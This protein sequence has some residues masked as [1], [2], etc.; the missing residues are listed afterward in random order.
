[1][2]DS[3]RMILE[4]GQAMLDDSLRL[5]DEQMARVLRLSGPDQ[6][7]AA[8]HWFRGEIRKAVAPLAERIEQLENKPTP[9]P[10]LQPTQQWEKGLLQTLGKFIA[11]EIDKRALAR[12][13]ELEKKISSL[14]SKITNWKYCGVWSAGKYAAFNF[15]T[16][17]GSLFVCLWDTEAQPGTDSSSWQLCCK[18]GK[19]GR[20]GRDGAENVRRLPSVQRA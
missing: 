14:E 5:L 13:E 1:M 16:H 18:R 17:Q 7:F 4:Q 2:T 9:S 6:V 12:I 10:A 11:A 3:E 8:E 20:D 15:V 19:D